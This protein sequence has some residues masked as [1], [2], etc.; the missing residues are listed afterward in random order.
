MSDSALLNTLTEKGL[1]SPPAKASQSY[2]MSLLSQEGTG[3]LADQVVCPDNLRYGLLPL[4]SLYLEQKPASQ[5]ALQGL[6][7]SIEFILALQDHMSNH[8]LRDQD[9]VTALEVLSL[10]PEPP[11]S[12]LAG[13]LQA[14]LRL[15]LSLRDFGRGD[16]RQALRQVLRSAQKGIKNGDGRSFLGQIHHWIH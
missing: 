10:K 1:F 14:V 2:A 6:V 16:V 8:G 15:E 7:T 11:Q 12:G 5:E 13:T 9:A 3:L 4:E